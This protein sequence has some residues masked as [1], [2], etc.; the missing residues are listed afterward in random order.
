[1]L[2][3]S[4]PKM[5]LSVGFRHERSPV[6]DPST[7]FLHSPPSDGFVAR[8]ASSGSLFDGGDSA[9]SGASL[10]D[11]TLQHQG[12]AADRFD[13]R[14]GHPYHSRPGSL[15]L[16]DVAVVQSVLGYRLIDS[17]HCRLI[18]HPVWGCGVF[19]SVLVSTAPTP[20]LAAIADQFWQGG[21]WQ[22]RWQLPNGQAPRTPSTRLLS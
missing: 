15:S 11:Y 22:R 4:S 18:Q 21:G 9:L 6:L 2:E 14:T 17:G 16:D 12:Y 5:A 3:D 20:E 8:L 1:M 7:Q 10:R 19:P 13:P